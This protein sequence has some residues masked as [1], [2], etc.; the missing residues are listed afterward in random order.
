MQ[1][2]TR[3]RE[4]R[5]NRETAKEAHRFCAK[6]NLQ[7]KKCMKKSRHVSHAVEKYLYFDALPQSAIVTFGG[8]DSVGAEFVRSQQ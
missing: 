6:L 2:G 3:C 7:T 8:S 4:T 1:V 5:W